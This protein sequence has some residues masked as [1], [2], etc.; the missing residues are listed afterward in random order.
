MSQCVEDI[1]CS[2][3]SLINA[4]RKVIKTS[5]KKPATFYFKQ[6][7]LAEVK[8]AQEEL[9]SRTWKIKPL[10]PFVLNE[11]GHRR[12][13]VGNAPYDRMIL[14]SYL[15]DG[16]EPLLNKYLIYD[17]YASQIGKGTGLA[18]KRFVEFANKAYLEYGHNH[19]YVLLIDFAK[20]YDN[21]QHEK[22]KAAILEKI[23]YEAFHE[24]MLDTILNSMKTDVS[25][26]T[27]EKYERCM[28]EMYV[29][30][31]HL[32][33][34]RGLRYM[35][36]GLQIG[37]HASQL[38]SVFYPTQTDTYCRCVLGA[39]YHGRFMDDTFIMHESKD[40]LREAADGIAERSA[41]MGL[42]I[43]KKKTQIFRI[44]KG[45]KYLNRIY[46]MDAHGC[47]SERI[48]SDTLKK[49]RVNLKKFNVMLN[50][51]SMTYEKIENQYRSWRGNFGKVTP[52]KQR[53]Q[54][55]TL[56]NEL[57]IKDFIAKEDFT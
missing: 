7:R 40:F 44:D 38:F 4:S 6:K 24:Y 28:D 3:E 36:K 27:N 45:V 14:H 43:N 9:R 35:A 42:F 20:F 25:F 41:K 33:E 49:E 10:K 15:D 47:V 17:N 12:K 29:A 19:F 56:Y 5:P 22:L 23:P 8:R 11:R 53:E 32:Y 55:D 2:A 46:R 18:R 13:I 51:G 30:L 48:H 37:N 39:K 54:L 50:D 1:V 34:N 57:F 21:V 16:L 52:E 26:M 31:D